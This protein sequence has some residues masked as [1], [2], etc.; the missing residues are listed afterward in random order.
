MRHALRE[1]MLMRYHRKMLTALAIA[2]AVAIGAGVY[3]I[4]LLIDT[5]IASLLP[6]GSISYLF[7]ADRAAK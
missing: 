2:A 5:V 1:G 4:S 3:Q 7:F 6:S